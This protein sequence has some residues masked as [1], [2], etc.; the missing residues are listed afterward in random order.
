[1][2]LRQRYLSI[3]LS[4][5]IQV[6][7]KTKVEYYFDPKLV[8][9]DE[10]KS[11]IA[12]PRKTPRKHLSGLQGGSSSLSN[13]DALYKSEHLFLPCSIVKSLDIADLAHAALVKTSDGALHKIRDSSQLIAV[14]SLDRT[15]VAD[16]LNLSDVS[17]QSLL[18]TL[19]LRYKR[20]DI[21]TTTGPILISI[22]P[23]KA[24]DGYYSV[25]RMH[26]YRDY[27]VKIQTST[28]AS[29]LST[30]RTSGLLSPSASI[31]TP[32]AGGTGGRPKPNSSPVQTDGTLEPHL[33]QVA[34]RA[35]A[36]LMDI[37]NHN[38][39]GGGGGSGGANRALESELDQ[40]TSA[41]KKLSLSTFSHLDQSI[42]ISGESGAGKTEATKYILQYLARITSE[43]DPKHESH[44]LGS[45]HTTME[46]RVLS[47]NPLL[48]SF[49]NA[50]TLRNDNSSRF[51]KFIQIQFHQ[52]G[53]IAGATISN[54]LLEKTR[55]TE[56]VD[57]E[58]NYHIFYQLI[59][60]GSNELLE[61]LGL[62]KSKF[63]GFH[64]ISHPKQ[65]S[66]RDIAAFEETKTCL[67]NIGVDTPEAQQTLF[68]IVAS[69]L[70]LG[71]V[72]FAGSGAD[73][74]GLSSPSPGSNSGGDGSSTII[75]TPDA[76]EKACELLGLNSADVSSAILSRQISVGG[77]TIMKPQSVVQARD[78][79]DAF[80]KLVYSSLFQWLV[81]QINI[82]ISN[83]EPA[84]LEPAFSDSM[85]QA[86]GSFDGFSPEPSAA[87]TALKRPT[88]LEDVRGFI[89][90]LDIYG[91]EHF[92]V[93]GFE[94]LLINYAN[95]NMQR[96]FNKHLFEVEQ[97]IYANEGVDWTY[98]TFNDN[99]PCLELLEG[100][101]GSFKVGI[102][103][104]L[105]DAW[106]G[107]GSASEKDVKFVSQ[108]HQT[109][110]GTPKAKHDYFV[111]PKFG[112]DRQ[113]G[114][115]HYAGEV[116]RRFA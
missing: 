103:S 85:L 99:R 113:F 41:T 1:M 91:F 6:T 95:E 67:S 101:G 107:M 20:D 4:I 110:G 115:C 68:G 12:T 78:K 92:D 22:N 111:T 34:D 90:V 97:E 56:Q 50:R 84:S 27:R 39:G 106:G 3:Y 49:G 38:S 32:K 87:G 86:A 8:L 21:Y 14:A 15:G 43:A 17:E 79:R 114:I 62:S 77:K 108:L 105:D 81:D 53:I 19:R 30:P 5:Y 116:R 54:Y 45:N 72:E 61:K 11:T 102:L 13:E 46:D 47:A 70:Y 112:A 31:P 24:I 44:G 58:R 74:D 55:I 36:A 98:I 35:Y 9:E 40:E 37:H 18:H 88:P 104:T 83:D 93:N 75:S 109:F 10:N 82:T 33:F 66:R 94:Q 76:L 73:S 65:P 59:T 57:G 89:G 28:V 16:V 2:L 80:S 100:G 29:A 51:G 7:G 42:I 60:G 96:H 63:K 64:Y 23:Y 26:L 69:V 25:E 48:E 52:T 71:N